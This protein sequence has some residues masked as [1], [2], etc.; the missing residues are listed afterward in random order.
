MQVCKALNDA[1]PKDELVLGGGSAG[2]KVDDKRRVYRAVEGGWVQFHFES[3]TC[4]W[5][6][7]K[8]FEGEMR[9]KSVTPMVDTL[10]NT[11]SDS[12]VNSGSSGWT[13]NSGSSGWTGPGGGESWHGNT[14]NSNLGS[15]TGGNI[16]AMYGDIYG[17]IHGDTGVSRTMQI[18]LAARQWWR[19][20]ARWCPKGDLT[21]AFCAA[22]P[23]EQGNVKE[24]VTAGEALRVMLDDWE[25]SAED[26]DSE[27]AAFAAKC[28][29]SMASG[30]LHHS[31]YS[32][33]RAG[34]V[35]RMILKGMKLPDIRRALIFSGDRLHE[36]GLWL[37]YVEVDALS[38]MDPA[39]EE[40]ML[41]IAA[42]MW[43]VAQVFLSQ[44]A[45]TRMC[46]YRLMQPPPPP[47]GVSIPEATTGSTAPEAVPS[48]GDLGGSPLKWGSAMSSSRSNSAPGPSH[49]VIQAS[50]SS[51]AV[52]SPIA[53]PLRSPV[54]AS[55]FLFGS[56]G[57]PAGTNSQK[58]S[59]GGGGAGRGVVNPAFAASCP[60]LQVAS[61]PGEPVCEAVI[62]TVQGLAMWTR[63]QGVCCWL[64]ASDEHA[65][66]KQSSPQDGTS[67]STASHEKRH[68]QRF[69]RDD[70]PPVF[71]RRCLQL[72]RCALDRR[73]VILARA[74]VTLLGNF[75]ACGEC[76]EKL[77]P[78]HH[79]LGRLLVAANTVFSTDMA[80]CRMLARALNYIY[81]HCM[82]LELLAGTRSVCACVC[83]CFC[84]CVRVCGCVCAR[85]H[86]HHRQGVY[87]TH[88]HTPSGKAGLERA[89]CKKG[90][91]RR[92]SWRAQRKQLS[93][94]SARKDKKEVSPRRQES[95]SS[96]SPERQESSA[97]T[98]NVRG[99]KLRSEFFLPTSPPTGHFDGLVLQGERSDSPPRSRPLAALAG[100][101]AK[102]SS[103]TS[104]GDSFRVVASA[105]QDRRGSATLTP[106]TPQT[107]QTPVLG[108]G[109]AGGGDCHGVWNEVEGLVALFELCKA[110][111][112][113][114][115]AWAAGALRECFNIMCHESSPEGQY[116][117]W[118]KFS[119]VFYILIFV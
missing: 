108:I 37:Q 87:N 5:V 76:I 105:V 58:V 62:L 60:E 93:A 116:R 31:V 20:R 104:S 103:D 80:L 13:V 19:M 82:I 22:P 23:T 48:E 16:S 51:A 56:L 101:V 83:V 55:G 4:R 12:S 11:T 17:D 38:V 115:L 117:K 15:W 77:W 43:K 46:L 97:N 40:D 47:S 66:G 72:L 9:M 27:A 79:E 69:L 39:V 44:G 118:H 110:S 74:S 28:V 6:T 99:E 26:Q 8:F 88:T 45:R 29:L 30:V 114:L 64:L 21:W 59:L 96:A 3:K 91:F 32:E 73:D 85:A 102:L 36:V 95:S 35:D 84:E 57:P 34:L 41:I 81:E 119:N 2:V 33:G 92:G 53:A 63:L 78:Y 7:D 70:S 106:Q 1:Y 94:S 67:P 109:G 54:A 24:E 112:L 71:S 98:P 89:V 75:L 68:E 65:Y 25:A 42:Q 49:A 113:V 50:L 90:A 86:T 61:V 107:P 52:K 14:R 18:K 111:D 100:H 10:K